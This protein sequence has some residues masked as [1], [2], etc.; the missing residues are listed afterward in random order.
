MEN[1]C[2]HLIMTQLNELL[3]ILQISEEFFD[4]TLGTWK[5]DTV[6]FELKE[7]EE[8]IWP[9]PDPVP[10]VHGEMFKNEVESLVLLGVLEVVNDSEWGSASF[11][12]PIPKSNRLCFLSDFSNI[13]KN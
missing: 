4:R 7:D 2:Q 10:K 6:D 9:R 8:T 5:T 3:K 11:A 12:Q 1:Q 13:N